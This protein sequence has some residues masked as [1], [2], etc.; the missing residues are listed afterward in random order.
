MLDKYR[1]GS[2]SRKHSKDAYYS[3]RTAG[4]LIRL[5]EWY[6]IAGWESLCQTC[7]CIWQS[8]GRG[9][10]ASRSMSLY[11]VPPQWKFRVPYTA[12]KASHYQW[13][14]HIQLLEINGLSIVIDLILDGWYV[15]KTELGLIDSTL[16]LAAAF[17]YIRLQ[18]MMSKKYMLLLN[19]FGF[20]LMNLYYST[21]CNVIV[22]RTL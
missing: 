6:R 2:W 19:A 22:E 16:A 4:W 1:T 18:Q 7:L 8:C 9:K 11:Q 5:C 10:H 14:C 17:L 20:L 3:Y 15:V 21:I 13:P 12:A